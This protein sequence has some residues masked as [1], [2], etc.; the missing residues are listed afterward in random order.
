M[1]VIGSR[2]WKLVRRHWNTIT[3]LR[4]K[5]MLWLCLCVALRLM[6]MIMAICTIATSGLRW[7]TIV[8]D[9]SA[10]LFFLRNSILWKLAGGADSSY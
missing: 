8:D 2:Q 7:G 10:S 9:A 4:V 3:A 6:T 1:R 5:N